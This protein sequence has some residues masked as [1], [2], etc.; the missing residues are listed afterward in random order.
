[1]NTFLVYSSCVLRLAATGALADVAFRTPAARPAADICEAATPARLERGRYL[2]EHMANCGICHSPR[3]PEK[4]ALTPDP[5]M[6]A[7][8][9]AFPAE[10]GPPGAVAAPNIT[11]GK[12][13]GIG[14]WSDGEKIRAI[15]EGISRDG[16]ALFAMM[17]YRFYARFSDEDTY[18]L[19]AYL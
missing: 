12:E 10:L 13:T 18:S 7:A 2:C 6:T 17:P 11:P 5:R 3:N 1:M 9:W 8:G 15:R 14:A 4:F 19:V 16:R